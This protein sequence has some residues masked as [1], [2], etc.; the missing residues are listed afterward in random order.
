VSD[1]VLCGGLVVHNVC[2]G[3]V[4]FCGFELQQESQISFKF[5]HNFLKRN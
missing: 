1:L 4:Y 5:F 3:G 2:G